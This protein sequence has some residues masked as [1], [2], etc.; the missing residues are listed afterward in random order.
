MKKKI[1]IISVLLLLLVTG[2]IATVILE[3]SMKSELFLPLH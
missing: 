2:L 1:V 3:K